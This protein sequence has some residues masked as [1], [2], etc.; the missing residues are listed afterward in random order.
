M[1]KQL[2]FQSAFAS[3]HRGDNSAKLAGAASWWQPLALA[4][5]R[6]GAAAT[7]TAASIAGTTVGIE[8]TSGAVALE[9]I[10]EPLSA[11]FTIAGTITGNLWGFESTMND[12]TAIN[13]VVD[14]IDGATGAITQIAKSARVTEL[15]LTPGSANNFTVTPTSTACK[16]G[17]RIRIRPFIDDAGAAMIVGTTT[18]S[19][20]GPTAAAAGDSWVQFTENLTF[21]GDLPA[22]ITQD[23]GTDALGF[24]IAGTHQRAQSFVAVTPGPITQVALSLAKSASPTDNV[25]IELQADSSGVPSGTALVSASIAGPSLTAAQATYR[26]SLPYP[27]VAGTTY[28]IVAKRSGAPDNTNNYTWYRASTDV[29]AGGQMAFH[30][31]TSWTAIATSAGDKR[32]IVY[33][34]TTY[35]LTD[36]AETINPGSATEKKALT[37]RG[38]GS[39]NAVTSTAAGPTA[40]IQLTATAGGTAVEWYTP[41][42]T[43][44]TLGGMAKFNVRALESNAA[45]NASL[46][47]EVAVVNG[48]GS[49]AVVWGTACVVN[50]AQ[51]GEIPTSEAAMVAWVAGDDV[52]ISD[53]QRLRFRVYVEDYAAGPLVTGNTV[54]VSYSGSSTGAAGDSYVILPIVITGPPEPKPKRYFSRS[55]FATVMRGATR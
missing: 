53:G 44:A 32:F 1:A 37:T 29:Y 52:A 12:N 5:A 31:G 40:G 3:I 25:T 38:S 13:F 27:C 6:G 14:K 47:C 50:D 30:D 9:W 42:L 51:A 43:P 26:V 24:G 54:T 2:F 35:Y 55:R 15:G 48:D 45:A 11:D 16:R 41:P 4:E 20:N 36:T 46:R 10:S 28:W 23:S 39:V 49:G 21:E 18:F 33:G 19:Y 34:G 17:D 8:F 7:A 22:L